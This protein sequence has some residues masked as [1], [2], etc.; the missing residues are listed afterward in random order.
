MIYDMDEDDQYFYL[1]EEYICGES[2]DTFLLHQP[3]ISMNLFF[4]IC[5]QLCDIFLYL[6]TFLPFPILYQDLKP[7]H[8]IVCGDQIKL[9]D[10]GVSGS[11]ANSGNNIKY[12][13]NVS[14]SAPENFAGA[15][16]STAA[17]VYSLGKLIQLLSQ[18]VEPSLSRTVSKI[19]QKSIQ[20]DPAL[21]Y[22]TVEALKSDL[23]NEFLKLRSTHLVQNIAVIGSHPGC[24]V[25]HFSIALVSALNL[26]FGNCYYMEGN[27]TDSIRR[28]SMVNHAMYEKEGCFYLRCFRGFPKCASGISNAAPGDAVF[29]TD[30][31]S[32]IEDSAIEQADLILFICDDAPWHWKD[33]LEKREFLHAHKDILRIIVNPGNRR[34]AHFYAKALG[35]PVCT[36]FSDNDAF[37]VTA[38]KMDYFRHLLNLK[39]K[40]AR[41]HRLTKRRNHYNTI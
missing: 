28:L 1:I 2:L 13:G 36:Y 41:P 40:H 4:S 34:S 31:G 7:E 39:G 29:V 24:G 27:D 8:I 38:R 33:A 23:E 16:L 14:F 10:F 37:S 3:I 11:A 17:D 35:L 9:I 22:E 18:Y 21:R 6:H 19:I 25:T 30:F 26:L 15:E 5:R 20:P 32:S 12:F